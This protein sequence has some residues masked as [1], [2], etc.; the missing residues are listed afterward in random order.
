MKICLENNIHYELNKGK[1]VQFAV[2]QGIEYL[3]KNY[4]CDWVFCFQQ[5]IFPMEKLFFMILQTK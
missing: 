1:G 3:S 5:D 2:N 4:D